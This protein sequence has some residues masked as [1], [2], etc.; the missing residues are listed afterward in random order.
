MTHFHSAANASPV[1]PAVGVVRR[2]RRWPIIA[3]LLLIA[4]P[5]ANAQDDGVRDNR[6]YPGDWSA[7]TS[8]RYVSSA[9]MTDNILYLGT[10][11]GI[12]RYDRYDNRWLTPLTTSNGLLSNEILAL[13]YDRVRDELF[14]EMPGGTMSY[15]RLSREWRIASV[16]P[17][18]LVQPF[19]PIDLTQYYLPFGYNVLDPRYI[20]TPNHQMYRIVG[21]IEDDLG[22]TWVATWGNFMWTIEAGSF[23]AVPARYGLYQSSVNAMLIDSVGM[24]FGGPVSLYGET[25]LTVNNRRENDWQ[26]YQSRFIPTF[27]SDIVFDIVARPDGDSVYLATD[28]GV[29]LFERKARRFTS[30]GKHNGM[31]DDLVLSLCLDGDILWIG[32]A[33][34]ID[35][36]YIPN[37]SLFHATTS[38]IQDARIYDIEVSDGIVWIGTDFGLYRLAKPTPVWRRYAADT[39]PLAGYVQAITPYGDQLYVGSD[40]GLAVIDVLGVKP[41]RSY[42]SPST[43]PYGDIYDIAVTDSI[44]W[45][46]TQSGLVRFVPGTLERRVIDESDGLLDQI[47]EQ[48]VV[49]GSYL[50]L[51]TYRGVNRFRWNNP[52]RID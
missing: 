35:G 18:E 6:Y 49:D 44:V 8:L 30:Y 36:L 41:I 40:R 14:A 16:F 48:I 2:R 15:Q 47:V 19:E 31:I 11:G 12:A 5:R 13:A 45:L 10:R 3:L 24:V 51:A 21:A 38:D 25:G 33:S 17:S 37:D 50:W 34:G 20:E 22:R 28:H 29:V 39:G 43:L 27:E 1:T 23:N 32:T 7:L 9:A 42:E 4:T 46:A 52:F 26:Y